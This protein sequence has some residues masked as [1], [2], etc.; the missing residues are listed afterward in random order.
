MRR[1]VHVV[2]MHS[3]LATIPGSGHVTGPRAAPRAAPSLARRRRSDARGMLTG[4][5]SWSHRHGLDGYQVACFFTLLG[6]GI[7]FGLFVG[8]YTGFIETTTP[9]ADSPHGLA[10]PATSDV[11]WTAMM[12][13][14]RSASQRPS[15]STARSEQETPWQRLAGGAAVPRGVRNVPLDTTEIQAVKKAVVTR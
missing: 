5:R 2:Q 15:G 6:C 14:Y 13:R 10:Q 8:G 9:P 12:R 3:G 4:V 7:L 1:S 11:G